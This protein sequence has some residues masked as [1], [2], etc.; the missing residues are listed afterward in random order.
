MKP[1]QRAITITNSQNAAERAYLL[2][3][4]RQ[5]LRQDTLC[6]RGRI[7]HGLRQVLEGALL[8]SLFLH[9]GNCGDTPVSPSTTA[10]AYHFMFSRR[11]TPILHRITAFRQG[12][13]RDPRALGCSRENMRR[14][15]RS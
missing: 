14:L 5:G 11:S 1:P 9:V 3:C 8:A 7:I 15:G 2:I 13:S 4:R 10:N 12:R 6:G